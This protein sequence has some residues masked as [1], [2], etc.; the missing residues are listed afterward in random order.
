[1]HRNEIPQGERGAKRAGFTMVEV[2]VA[3]GVLLVAI[4]TAFGGQLTSYRLMSSSREDTVGHEQ[5][6]A[7]STVKVL[8]ALFVEPLQRIRRA[9]IVPRPSPSTSRV[10][11]IV[12]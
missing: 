11:T 1:M 12:Q 5:L 7:L 4:M 9:S 8:G 10:Q 6:S 2:M 3:I